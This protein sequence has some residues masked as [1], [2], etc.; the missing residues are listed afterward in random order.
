MSF[1]ETY[2]KDIDTAISILKEEGCKEVYI[3][4]SVASGDTK[5]DSDIDIAVKGIKKGSFFKIYTKLANA[6]EH[7][8][9]FIDLNSN[10]RFTKHIFEI[11]DII[12]VA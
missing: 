7:Q 11:G 12:R 5:T 10:K 6:L 1:P 4:G 8:V 9:D 3:F 2:Q